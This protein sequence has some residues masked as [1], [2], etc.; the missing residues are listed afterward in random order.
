[1]NNARTKIFALKNLYRKK[2]HLY[3]F[4][5]LKWRI[6]HLPDKQFIMILAAV[7]GFISGIIAFLI[8]GAVHLIQL[9]LKSSFFEYTQNYLYIIF[10]AIGILLTVLFIKYIIRKKVDHGIPGVLHSISKQHGFIKSHNLFSSIIT[11][12]F[13][14]GFGG[15]VGLEGPT[16]ATG[17]AYGSNLGK[18]F[19][20]S[21]K[22]RILLLGA[23]ASGAMA[24]IFKAPLAGVV[25]ALE[26]IMI[27]LTMYSVIPIL[28]ASITGAVTSYFLFGLGVIY[29]FE[30]K[31]AFVM[32]D[33]PY[34]ILLGILTGLVSSYFTRVYVFIEK[35]FS[36]FKR[37]YIRLFVGA[38]LL[39]ILIWFFPSFYGE[40]YE[41]TNSA[42]H[43]N[44]DYL[45]NNYLFNTFSENQVVIIILF[46]V[47]ILF[48]VVATSITFGSGGVGGIFAPTL[49]TGA[50]TGL[51][52]TYLIG[53]FGIKT[54]SR[55]NFAM[56]GMAGMIA[57]VLHAPLTA[58]FLIGDL[59]GGYGLFVPLMIVAT[60]SFATVRFF[61]KNSVYTIQ[62]AK[63][64][65]LMTHH[66][67]KNVLSMMKIDKLIEKDFYILRPNSNLKE[68]KEAFIN[69]K[70]NVFPVVDEDKMF[71]GNIIV[72]DIKDIIFDTEKYETVF[73][74]QLMFKPPT[75][76]ELNDN[77]EEVAQKIQ[78]SGLFNIVVLNKGKYIGFVSR[79]NVFSSYRRLLKH[80]SDE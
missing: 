21:Y 61:H 46:L 45:F 4:K 63:R 56:V 36:R 26:V 55:E 78:K 42:L 62:L 72:A 9:M 69:S 16:V 31:T 13:T 53:A 11:S 58:I 74:S 34:Y 66:K 15:S 6:K 40:G 18:I 12:A 23:A 19:H 28:I 37:K 67:D 73:A 29:P 80:F 49:F 1:M 8:K 64:G 68:I 32:N 38:V 77:M 79:A 47:I 30:I 52:F 59:T 65:E 41:V 50:N 70:R 39:G 27:D 22:H 17:A 54:L 60:I 25:F 7:I 35:V 57:G 48:K 3:S 2:M 20:L 5:L 14:V 33:I 10:P 75:H 43:G 44:F 24:A 51:F 76:I 71:L